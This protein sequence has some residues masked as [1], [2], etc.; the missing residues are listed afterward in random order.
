MNNGASAT[1]DFYFNM[2]TQVWG[3]MKDALE[4]NFSA[5]L[6]GKPPIIELPYDDELIK[7]LSNR[8]KKMSSKGKIQLES[9]DDMKKR[10]I[11]SP[12]I[13]DAVTL[14]YHNPNTWIF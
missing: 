12:D 6:Q 14:A 13:A 5:A 9:K 7:Q 1:D 8:K 2:G 11:G 3:E 4:E 10:S